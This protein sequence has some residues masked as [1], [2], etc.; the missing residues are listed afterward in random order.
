MASIASPA[1]AAGCGKPASS[2]NCP[3]CKKLGVTPLQQ[4]CGQTCFEAFWP[5]HKEVHKAWKA[6]QV[7]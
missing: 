6:K 3:T 2:L 1:C 4:F 7:A 5:K